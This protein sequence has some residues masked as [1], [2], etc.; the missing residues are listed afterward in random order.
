MKGLLLVAEEALGRLSPV[1]SRTWQFACWRCYGMWRRFPRTWTWCRNPRGPSLP[2][3]LAR[4]PCPTLPEN[5]R[6]DCF[7]IN[8]QRIIDFWWFTTSS[9]SE[10]IGCAADREGSLVEGMSAHRLGPSSGLPVIVYSCL[11]PLFL[12]IS[13]G[14]GYLIIY[15][16]FNYAVFWVQVLPIMSLS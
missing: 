7:L 13:I 4:V 16:A 8:S 10:Y 12:S 9:P 2:V 6:W 5:V 3:A 11:F 14:H 15:L 1:D